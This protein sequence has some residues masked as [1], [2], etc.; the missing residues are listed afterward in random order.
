MR[1]TIDSVK[2]TVADADAI[3]RQ[4]RDDYR[5]CRPDAGDGD[6]PRMQSWKEAGPAPPLAWQL[7]DDMADIIRTVI[8]NN[9]D[10]GVIASAALVVLRERYEGLDPRDLP[11]AI[12]SWEGFAARYVPLPPERVEELIGRMV[13]AGDLIS[14]VSCGA[15]SKSVCGCGAPYVGTHRWTPP[16]TAVPIAPQTGADHRARSRQGCR[17]G[18]SGKVQPRARRRI[19]L[20]RQDDRQ[21]AAPQN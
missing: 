15:K 20:R 14:C 21:G 19:W 7:N 8:N 9:T 1:E 6:G 5:L 2:K 3:V 17:H 18:P 13:H 11:D 16:V 10:R 4:A 12:Q